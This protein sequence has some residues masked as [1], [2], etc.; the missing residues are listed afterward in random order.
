MTVLT[1][2]KIIQ[3]FNLAKESG[4]PDPL[5]VIARGYVKTGLDFDGQYKGAVGAFGVDKKQAVMAGFDDEELSFSDSNL[6]A[7]IQVDLNNLRKVDNDLDSMY[8]E[9]NGAGGKSTD[10]FM[11]RLDKK[12]RSLSERM[13]FDEG[14]SLVEI[15]QKVKN[16]G[17]DVSKVVTFDDDAVSG[18]KKVERKDGVS[19]TNKISIGKNQDKVIYSK[20]IR[21]VTTDDVIK[22]TKSYEFR[23]KDKDKIDKMVQELVGI[24]IDEKPING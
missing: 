21:D 2:D 9:S 14:G 7:T 13:I 16:D 6:S 15:R 5:G 1:D 3:S 8:R 24:I 18:G 11:K 17:L 20:S 19:T 10:R 4:H 23:I 12:K 22:E